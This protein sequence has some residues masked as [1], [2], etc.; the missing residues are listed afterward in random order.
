MLADEHLF[1]LHHQLHESV[2]LRAYRHYEE[3]VVGEPYKRQEHEAEK[4]VQIHSLS[5]AHVAQRYEECCK[6]E[7]D[8]RHWV[9]TAPERHQRDNDGPETKHAIHTIHLLSPLF[10]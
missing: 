10:A 8:E 7:E 6:T 5:Q 2:F 1:F 9:Q 3:R 4:N